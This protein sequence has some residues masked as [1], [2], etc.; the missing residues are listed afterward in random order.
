[1]ARIY[2]I[3]YT[4]SLVISIE[5]DVNDG[6]FK[7]N[8]PPFDSYGVNNIA[9]FLGSSVISNNIS[10]LNRPYVPF[11]WTYNVSFINNN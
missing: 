2:D 5:G 4:T 3:I 11:V 6:G 10:C 1:M 9:D 7:T 8:L